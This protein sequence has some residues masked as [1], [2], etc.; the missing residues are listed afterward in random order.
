MTTSVL[1][2]LM[3]ELSDKLTNNFF[4]IFQSLPTLVLCDLREAFVLSQ[5]Q[6]IFLGY[7]SSARA[8]Q[9]HQ[10]LTADTEIIQIMEKHHQNTILSRGKNV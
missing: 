10:E 3:G 4:S 6:G 8:H 5:Y 1:D 2:L 7:F 9:V